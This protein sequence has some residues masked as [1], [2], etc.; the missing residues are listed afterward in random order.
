[1]LLLANTQGQELRQAHR[2]WLLEDRALLS[3]AN[4]RVADFH[5]VVLKNFPPP[6]RLRG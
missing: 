1:M 4:N 2:D 6:V 5:R 3:S